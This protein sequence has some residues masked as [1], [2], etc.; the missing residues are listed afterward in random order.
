MAKAQNTAPEKKAEK[1]AAAPAAP[2]TETA[3]PPAAETKAAP[4]APATETATPPAAETKAAP[5]AKA[6][7][8]AVAIG[9]RVVCTLADG[10][11]Y[12]ADVMNN[13]PVDGYYSLSVNLGHKHEVSE[14]KHISQAGTEAGAVYWQE[15][16][17]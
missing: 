12:P 3:T 7:A 5:A 16:Q 17:S 6:T 11:Q 2:A 4:A 9:Q 10:K 8:P 15:I 14:V 13:A 1:T